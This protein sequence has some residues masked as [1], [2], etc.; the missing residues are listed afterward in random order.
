M[1]ALKLALLGSLITIAGCDGCNNEFPPF[2]PNCHDT[3]A[4]EGDTDTDSDGDTDSDT[5]S[6]TDAD[7]DTDAEFDDP[8]D[9]VTVDN[10]D[11]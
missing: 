3:D 11:G 6:D 10:E 1:R 5:D 2:C 8:G 7:G 9:I 4:V